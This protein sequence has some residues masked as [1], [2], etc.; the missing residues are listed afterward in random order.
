MIKGFAYG[1]GMLLLGLMIEY[2]AHFFTN[3][4][5]TVFFG[6]IGM[7]YGLIYGLGLVLKALCHKEKQ[8]G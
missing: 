4:A 8:H 7:L 3:G 5:A 1:L 2:C 6:I